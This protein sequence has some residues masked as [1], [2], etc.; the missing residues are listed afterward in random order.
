[1]GRFLPV[2]RRKNLQGIECLSGIPGYTGGTPVQNVGAYGQEVSETIASVMCYDRKKKEFVE[3][4]NAECAFAY[5]TSV[6]NTTE[7][8]RYIVT[9]VTFALKFGGEPKIVYRD[10][11]NYFGD[12][13]PNL[14]DTRRAVLKIRAEKSM[15]INEK[16]PNSRSVGSFS[17]IRLSLKRSL[18][19]SKNWLQSPACK[20]SVFR[21]RQK[22]Q[23]SR[24][25]AYRKQRFWQRI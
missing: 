8:N 21:F 24:R 19:K 10:L 5:R 25:L 2:L 6:F 9:A 14:E 7:K 17:K 18:R 13:K 20:R 22:C 1:M 23:N 16:D 15:V 3:L 4:T 11:K 12:A